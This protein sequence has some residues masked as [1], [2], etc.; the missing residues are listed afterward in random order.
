MINLIYGYLG[1]IPDG[2]QSINIL[3]LLIGDYKISSFSELI[4][5]SGSFLFKKKLEILG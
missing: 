1:V 3:F 4:D 2:I 5:D